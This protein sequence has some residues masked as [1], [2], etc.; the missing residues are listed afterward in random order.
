MNKEKCSFCG[1]YANVRMGECFIDHS[2]LGGECCPMCY[3]SNQII[4]IKCPNKKCIG[5][6]VNMIK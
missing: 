3:N 5:G 4:I 6:V 1:E 2:K